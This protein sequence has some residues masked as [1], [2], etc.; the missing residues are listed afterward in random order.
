MAYSVS[1]NTGDLI[2]MGVVGGGGGGEDEARSIQRYSAQLKGQRSH[3]L[4]ACTIR[5]SNQCSP[6]T[7]SW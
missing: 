3:R 7:P 6:S 2:W 5:D 1:S 4:P